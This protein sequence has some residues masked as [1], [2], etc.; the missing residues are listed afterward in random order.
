MGES[1][2]V[3]L[4]HCGT[5]EGIKISVNDQDRTASFPDRLLGRIAAENIISPKGKKVIV[6][7]NE[8]ITEDK[9][10]EI[11]KEG[12]EEAIVRSPITCTLRYGMCANCYGWDFSVRRKVALGVPVGVVA[13]QSI[14][15]PGTQLTMRTRYVAGAVMQDV[16]HGLP[17]VEELFEMRTPKALSPISEVSGKL[18]IETGED[19]YVLKVSSHRKPV[20]ER[21]Y[22]I[23]LASSL[24][25]KDGQEVNIGTQFAQGYLDPKEVLKIAGL[26]EAQ[27]YVITEAQ[28]VYESQGIAINDKHFEVILRKMSDKVVVETVGDGL[29]EIETNNTK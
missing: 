20:E 26:V 9:I 8:E 3:L 12:V 23:P 24:T 29:R 22:F 6:K 15:E 10:I 5:H 1:W 16:T 18:K 25:V 14:G 28:K 11:S 21:E 19:G 17:R 7:A 13:A 2:R 4:G 27:R